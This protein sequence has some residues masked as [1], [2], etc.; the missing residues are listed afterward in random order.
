MCTEFINKICI[1]LCSAGVGRTGTFIV[2]DRLLQHMRDNDTV[3]VYGTI[4]EMR[5][6]RTNMVQTEVSH[7]NTNLF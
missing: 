2:V 4:M 6:C 7:V 3:D 1:V 5:R